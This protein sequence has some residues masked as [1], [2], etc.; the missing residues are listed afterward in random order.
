M[1]KIKCNINQQ[2]LKRVDLHFV[3]SEWFSLTWSCGSR[4]RDTTSSEWKFRLNN[5]AVNGLMVNPLSV[6]LNNI[7]LHVNWLITYLW[8]FYAAKIIAKDHPNGILSVIICGS[9]FVCISFILLKCEENVSGIVML[10]SHKYW[11]SRFLKD[12]IIMSNFGGDKIYRS[13]ETSS[14]VSHS[15]NIL[16]TRH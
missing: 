11:G 7:Y 8:Y 6:N 2:D 10:G 9:A 15:T 14:N 13:S 5:L 16:I 12:L 1:L 4:Q 3:K